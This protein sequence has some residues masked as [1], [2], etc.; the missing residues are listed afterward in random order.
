MMVRVIEMSEG[1]QASFQSL[2]PEENGKRY[3][4]ALLRAYRELMMELALGWRVP[5]QGIS[6]LFFIAVL[7][8]PFVGKS[9]SSYIIDKM[10][11]VCYHF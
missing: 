5:D 1:P 3:D 10:P 8:F 9:L 11:A 2:L 4:T 7:E 6:S